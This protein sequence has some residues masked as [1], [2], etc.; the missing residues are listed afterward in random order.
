MNQVLKG[1]TGP[2]WAAEKILGLAEMV[3]LS[4]AISSWWCGQRFPKP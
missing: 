4:L 1:P 3:L 2:P